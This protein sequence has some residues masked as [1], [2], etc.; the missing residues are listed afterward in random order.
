MN[1]YT[2]FLAVAGL[3]GA[4]LGPTAAAD[5]PKQPARTKVAVLL[6]PGVE[7]LDFAGPGEAFAVASDADGN[8]LFE[9][10]TVGLKKEPIKSQGYLTVTPQYDSTD[11]PAPDV[12][13]I[14][15]GNVVPVMDDPKAMA[16]IAA[17]AQAK[18][19]MF[20]VC[21]GATVL[22]KAGLLDGLEVTTH[23]GNREILT[24]I[25][26]KVICLKDRRFVD[27]GQVVT[28]AGVS[29]GIDG[30]LHV[31]GRLKGADVARR[32]ATGM[33]FDYWNGFDPKADRLTK[34]KS[35]AVAQTGRVHE[36]ERRWAV[37]NLLTTLRDKGVAEAV[38]AYPSLLEGAKG[39]DRE[40]IEEAGL[41]ETAEWLLK[42]S[43]DP[44]LGLN[45]LR[46][47][48][49]VHS[50]SSAAHAALGRGLIEKKK[51]AEAKQ[52]LAKAVELDPKNE[53]AKKLFESIQ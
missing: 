8:D 52:A 50:K 46:F 12:L 21:N 11:A 25:A 23:H 19:L 36:P 15:G 48:A 5:P 30:A 2:L 16:W 32:A 45:A 34:T 9:V 31:I 53:A 18:C 27:N 47:V 3:L 26:P 13:V 28:A 24:A 33:E 6:F 10:Y 41:T 37:M 22:A 35:G 17:R 4:I 51:P 42:H 40:M 14:P 44:D 43:R 39:H 29:A 7:L 1:R 49:E 20:S 38:K